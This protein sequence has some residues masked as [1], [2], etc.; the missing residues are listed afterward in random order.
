M[1]VYTCTWEV[2]LEDTCS[3]QAPTKLVR[4]YV[5]NKQGMVAHTCDASYSGG[6]GRKIEILC[7][8]GQTYQEYVSENKLKA[9]DFTF[10]FFPFL[11]WKCN[12][13]SR[14]SLMSLTVGNIVY[15]TYKKKQSRQGIWLRGRAFS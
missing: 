5:K 15:H 8:P 6:R 11:F 2:E 4:P 14:E 9:T 3:R 1:V 10:P 12:G 13:W 7:Q